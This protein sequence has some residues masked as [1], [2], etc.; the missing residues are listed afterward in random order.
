[1]HITETVRLEE[2]DQLS[3]NSHSPLHTIGTILAVHPLKVKPREVVV[4]VANLNTT[5]QVTNLNME[6]ADN[7]PQTKITIE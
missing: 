1:M 3:N 5:M 4:L 6:L 2:V 7:I